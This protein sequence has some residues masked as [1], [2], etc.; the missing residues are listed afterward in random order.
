MNELARMAGVPVDDRE[1]LSST[2]GLSYR[3]IVVLVNRIHLFFPCPEGRVSTTGLATA[4][5][6][7]RRQ[8]LEELNAQGGEWTDPSEFNWYFED[9]FQPK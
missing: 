6:R 9:E 7:I 4:F 5:P 1:A 2:L 3:E 8:Y